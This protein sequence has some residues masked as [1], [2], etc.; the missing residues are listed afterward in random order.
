MLSFLESSFLLSLGFG[1]GE[2]EAGLLFALLLQF[3]DLP[4]HVLEILF[5]LFVVRRDLE[6]LLVMLER[7][8]PIRHLR[9]ILLLPLA[10]LVKSVAKI[11]MTLA[12]QA[13]IR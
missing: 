10:A 5:R 1:D 7:V 2:G 11:V 9:V 8:R 13:G 6:A 3:L 4:F 12:L